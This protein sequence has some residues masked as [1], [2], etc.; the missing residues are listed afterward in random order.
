MWCYLEVRCLS[1]ESGPLMNGIS[2]FK[3]EAPQRPVAHSIM[4]R[5]G[6]KVPAN[7]EE[8]LLQKATMLVPWSWTLQPQSYE[9]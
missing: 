7:Q 4:W 6:E 5:Q 8:G 1:L 3:K 9:K 2:A